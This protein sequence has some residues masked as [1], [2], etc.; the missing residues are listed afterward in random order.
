MNITEVLLEENIKHVL[1]VNKW[2][3]DGD[4]LEREEKSAPHFCQ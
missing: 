2:V 1:I 3:E 4:T